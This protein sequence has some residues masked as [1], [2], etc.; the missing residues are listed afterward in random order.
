LLSRG[1][2]TWMQVC[3]TQ[4][5]TTPCQPPAPAAPGMLPQPE[6]VYALAALVM[7]ELTTLAVN[8]AEVDHD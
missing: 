7:G 3:L 1:M 2:A 8:R 6:Y 4:A 5:T